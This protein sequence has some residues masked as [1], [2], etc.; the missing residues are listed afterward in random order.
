MLM[1]REPSKHFNTLVKSDDFII[2]C[3]K[4]EIYSGAYGSDLIAWNI[5]LKDDNGIL[6]LPNEQL[7]YS[8][9][10][11]D[12]MYERVEPGEEDDDTI[13]MEYKYEDEPIAV[14]KL[15]E[16]DSDIRQ[17]YA[18]VVCITGAE[19][20]KGKVYKAPVYT[21]QAYPTQEYQDAFLFVSDNG[22]KVFI[23]RTIPFFPDD[24]C[25]SDTFEEISLDEFKDFCE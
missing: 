14:R 23:K 7:V 10:W 9:A 13:Y 3:D 2:L 1:N 6:N 4:Q 5:L 18:D 12:D 24:N 11:L 21:P 16:L 17:M 20:I 15:F 19:I 25:N 8:E 22:D